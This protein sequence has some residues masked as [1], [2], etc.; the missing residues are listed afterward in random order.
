MLA[1]AFL[2]PPRGAQRPPGPSRHRGP[3]SLSNVLQDPQNSCPTPA[4][5]LRRALRAAPPSLWQLSHTSLAAVSLALSHDQG[6]RF[7]RPVDIPKRQWFPKSGLNQNWRSKVC[8]LPQTLPA[9]PGSHFP[10]SD[11]AQHPR[12]QVPA[13]TTDALG[14]Q[15]PA[16]PT[17]HP[18]SPAANQ[19]ILHGP[20]FSLKN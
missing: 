9:Q 13:S 16:P 19:S 18:C 5:S 15:S 7:S 12:P 4:L 2:W 1:L 20:I 14:R 10:P 17:S 6:N 11:T 3:K 8:G